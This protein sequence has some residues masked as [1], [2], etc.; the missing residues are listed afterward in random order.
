VGLINNLGAKMKGF[1]MSMRILFLML[2]STNIWA[3]KVDREKIRY[4]Y[5]L[6]FVKDELRA[7]DKITERLTHHPVFFGD[8]FESPREFTIYKVDC[9]PETFSLDSDMY[10]TVPVGTKIRLNGEELIGRYRMYELRIELGE[11]GV[12]RTYL[13]AYEL[14][15]LFWPANERDKASFYMTFEKRKREIV[16]KLMVKYKVSAKEIASTLGDMN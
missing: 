9:P 5:A 11:H 16:Q 2:L 13:H 7:Y 12:I 6:E 1:I 4:E 3:Q 14:D 15:D 10:L 8:V